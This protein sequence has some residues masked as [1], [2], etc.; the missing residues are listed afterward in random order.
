MTPEKIA[1]SAVQLRLDTTNWPTDLRS[2]ATREVAL[3]NEAFREA[4][5][6]HA[7]YGQF[8]H[9]LMASG[10]H[11]ALGV[12][13]ATK[14]W[15]DKE[16]P[17]R[18]AQ[19][20]KVRQ[21]AARVETNLLGQLAADLTRPATESHEIA[22]L[23]E[24]RAWLRGLPE[25]ERLNHARTLAAQG[26]DSVLRAILT[27]PTYLSGVDEKLLGEVKDEAIRR[28]HPDRHAKLETFRRAA[29]AADR[30]LAGVIHYIEQEASGMPPR[31]G[32][33][34]AAKR[35]P[36]IDPELN[37]RI[38]AISEEAFARVEPVFKESQAA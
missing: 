20:E 13:T 3:L 2:N 23:Q 12:M 8:R 15:V 11:T 7:R 36:P 10:K 34:V 6:L 18:R 25:L 9:E 29:L 24:I 4:A 28:R 27:A 32:V 1:A 38:R 33:L 31:T 22:L 16:L 26:D 17:A 30:A 19:L 14:D 37:R 5:N 21:T 35:Q